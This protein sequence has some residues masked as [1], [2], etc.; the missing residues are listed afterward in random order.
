MLMSR[1]HLL[2]PVLLAVTPATAQQPHLGSVITEQENLDSVM[3]DQKRVMEMLTETGSESKLN[4]RESGDP[5]L[6]V[7]SKGLHWRLYFVQCLG[8][9]RCLSMTM[10]ADFAAPGPNANLPDLVNK[11]NSLSR[12]SRVFV[13]AG[14]SMAIAT[15][16]ALPHASDEY[17][18]DALGRWIDGMQRFHTFLQ[19]ESVRH[20]NSGGIGPAR[21][22]DGPNSL[23]HGG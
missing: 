8:Q 20:A 3:I 22:P 11:W 12:F 23:P 19:P 9:P 18:Q 14:N 4:T 21:I 2:L 5:W 15:D 16:V 1:A 13:D 10:Q 17:V 7:D 6:D